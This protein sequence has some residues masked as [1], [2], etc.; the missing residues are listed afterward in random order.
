MAGGDFLFLAGAC[1]A[2]TLIRNWSHTSK[3]KD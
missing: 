1:A 2:M 3:K